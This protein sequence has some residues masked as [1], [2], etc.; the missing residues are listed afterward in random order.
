MVRMR[1]EKEM[2]E[3]TF[4]PD[5]GDKLEEVQSLTIDTDSQ[6]AEQEQMMHSRLMPTAAA[7]RS[8]VWKAALIT[9]TT[10]AIFGAL[11][12]T[13][14][15]FYE[16]STS[17][18]APLIQPNDL[19]ALHDLLLVGYAAVFVKVD[20]AA[21]QQVQDMAVDLTA[22]LP[23]V[24]P[25]A[26]CRAAFTQLEPLA[27]PADTIAR[28]ARVAWDC[29]PHEFKSTDFSATFDRQCITDVALAKSAKNPKVLPAAR[30][31]LS[32]C[33]ASK[34]D[35]TC[36]YWSVIH[37]TALWAESSSQPLVLKLLIVLLWSGATQCSG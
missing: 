5:D 3:R 8:R 23:V 4:N 24:H 14:Y 26:P 21:T 1:R 20:S 16:P 28:A 6:P 32:T 19:Y 37:S 34:W 15:I 29:L 9:L 31:S 27:D 36:S 2:I 13:F 11:C 35:R 22:L 30:S 17:N 33:E 25:W 12:L 7:K 18:P 10:L